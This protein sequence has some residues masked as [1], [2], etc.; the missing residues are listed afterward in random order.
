MLVRLHTDIES[1]P[2]A[3]MSLVLGGF[4]TMQHDRT[5]ERLTYLAQYRLV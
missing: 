5:S 2:S 1:D 4:A 3:G